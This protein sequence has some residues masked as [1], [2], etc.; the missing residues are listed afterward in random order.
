MTSTVEG[1]FRITETSDGVTTVAVDLGFR[2]T[3]D[4]KEDR[5]AVLAFFEID[6]GGGRFNG[7]IET[8]VFSPHSSATVEF[9]SK[10][11]VLSL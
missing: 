3:Q 7:G 4:D 5:G 8:V 1:L 2:L 11:I 9:N 10:S 6:A